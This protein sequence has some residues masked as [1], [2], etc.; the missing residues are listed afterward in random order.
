MSY[1]NQTLFTMKIKQGLM[2][3]VLSVLLSACRLNFQGASANV[4]EQTMTP[5]STVAALSTSTTVATQSSTQ[6][7]IQP[8]QQT[9][10]INRPVAQPATC[11]PRTNW[12]VYTIQP[13]D[14]LGQ[15]ATRTGTDVQTLAQANCL[16][17]VNSISVGASLYVPV[18][19]QAAAPV[20]AAQSGQSGL[21]S[22][23]TV[24]VAR[25][26]QAVDLYNMYTGTG[27]SVV[28]QIPAN[29]TLPVTKIEFN[30]CLSLSYDGVNGWADPRGI[31]LI[32]AVCANLVPADFN[33][34]LLWADEENDE[35]NAMSEPYSG[36]GLIRF[37]GQVW[38]YAFAYRPYRAGESEYY[39]KKGWYRV[40]LSNGAEAWS[41]DFV[42]RKAGHCTGLPES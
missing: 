12:V 41:P 34:C 29:A 40:R 28:G 5:V 31:N 8:T 30:G 13:N 36:Q 38:V 17:D 10:S 14:T 7:V 6:P 27:A 16:T 26:T 42:Q 37:P 32:S 11:Q 35:L 18:L 9:S 21:S 22:S 2:L 15:I 23:S 33:A 24:C 1:I 19:P 4:Q 3:V 39:G 20:Q 25:A